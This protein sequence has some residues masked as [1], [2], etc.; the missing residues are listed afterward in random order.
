MEAASGLRGHAQRDDPGE[1]S[2]REQRRLQ[3]P[4]GRERAVEL[5]VVLAGSQQPN[6]ALRDLDGMQRAVGRPVE[7]HA[8]IVEFAER[9]HVEVA[10]RIAVRARQEVWLPTGIDRMDGAPVGQRR[11]R[12][13]RQLAE[14]HLVVHGRGERAARL[15]E[16]RHPPIERFRLVAVQGGGAAAIGVLAQPRHQHRDPG[17]NDTDDQ[18]TVRPARPVAQGQ[19]GLG[20]I[21]DRIEHRQHGADQRGPEAPDEPRDDDSEEQHREWVEHRRP[22]SGELVHDDESRQ[23]Q[24]RPPHD[25]GPG[26]PVGRRVAQAL[27]PAGAGNVDELRPATLGHVRPI[28]GTV[29]AW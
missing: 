29:P 21:V 23:R 15:R 24:E 8:A 27:A 20:E 13:P 17:R 9:A 12:D 3:R 16:E 6:T 26:P 2:L 5:P 4:R 19:P 7:R 22:L 18:Q 28:P 11:H 25:L 14:G 1:P 10:G